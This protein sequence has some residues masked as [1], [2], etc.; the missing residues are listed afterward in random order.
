MR[1][2]GF[3]VSCWGEGRQV[4]PLRGSASLSA[5]ISFGFFHAEDKI[6]EVAQLLQNWIPLYPS[7]MSDSD[8]KRFQ[9]PLDETSPKDK[10]GLRLCSS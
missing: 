8:T 9:Y 7:V 2:E 5:S 6:D 1:G 3:G 10:G 4:F